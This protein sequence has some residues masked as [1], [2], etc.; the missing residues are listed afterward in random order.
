[1]PALDPEVLSRALP[2]LEA[3]AADQ[4]GVFSVGQAIAAG[5]TPAH[6]RT[7]V[8][9][10]TWI[11]VR[12]GVL[13]LASRWEQAPLLTS[14]A[15]KL[16]RLSPEAVVSHASAWNLYQLPYLEA[17]AEPTMTVPIRTTRPTAGVLESVLPAEQ[18]LRFGTVPVT[19][20]PRTVVDVLRN[21]PDRFEALTLADGALRDGVSRVRVDEMINWCEGWPGIQ[22]ARA[23][24]ALAEALSESPL[25]SRH[26]LLFREA[27]LPEPE[28]QVKV[29]DLAGRV[30]ARVDFLFR[31]QRT[32]VESDGKVKYLDDARANRRR[33][34]VL[35]DEKVRED[36]L[37]DLGLEVVR[38]TWADTKDG[39]HDLVRRVSRA[40][41][42]A[43]RRAA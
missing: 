10:G 9:R 31:A 25:E 5:L 22:Q 1:M 23:A 32:V 33:N 27:G 40:F 3:R 38:A 8:R 12:H 43:A 19:T 11:D 15:G 16:L 18:V 17:P 36:R 4:G 26:R 13:A 42:R 37:R 2:V 30:V 35:W 28:L 6:V 24:W 21:A 7:L 34:D 39:G 41:D 20:G 14:C 29:R